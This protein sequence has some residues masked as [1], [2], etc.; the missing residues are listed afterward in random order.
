MLPKIPSYKNVGHP[1]W[2]PSP[3]TVLQIH[4]KCVRSILEYGVISTITVLDN[5]IKKFQKL[6]NS[7]IKLA[8]RLP[9]Y[10]ATRLLY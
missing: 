6:Q 4:K 7:F 9:R 5:V 1:K 3:Q 8:L 2:G 10:I